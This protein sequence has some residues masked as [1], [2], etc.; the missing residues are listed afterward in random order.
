MLAALQIDCLSSIGSR[1]NL[2]VIVSC[3]STCKNGLIRDGVITSF[4]FS[5]FGTRI[6]L[7]LGESLLAKTSG[8]PVLVKWFLLFTVILFGRLSIEMSIWKRSLLINF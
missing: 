5:R 6:C 3:I 4:V 2:F 7:E 8:P 1:V